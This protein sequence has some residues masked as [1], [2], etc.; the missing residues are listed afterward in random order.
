[1]KSSAPASSGSASS[2]ACQNVEGAG[3]FSN[4]VTWDFTTLNALPSDLVA[5]TEKNK[6]PTA[7]YERVA[8]PS[9]STVSGGYLNMKV[10]GGQS[11]S[12][13]KTAQ[14]QT[15][16]EGMLFASIRTTA[17]LSSVQ[18]ICHGF[19]FYNDAAEE[20]DIEYL[21]DPKSTSNPGDG[22]TPLQLT[23]HGVGSVGKQYDTAAIPSDA[24][25]KAHEY[26][27]D[28]VDG[29][30]SHYIDGKKVKEFTQYVPKQAGEWIWNN[31]ADGNKDWSLGPPA[32]DSTLK[33]SKIEMFYNTTS[34]KC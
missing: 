21:S 23:N 24:T 2:G 22:S 33:I 7:P 28:W 9:L 11:S 26:R 13:I 27:T 29:T 16:E 5:T 12:P 30:V 4:H 6:D 10:P 34:S 32:Q 8:D 3:V 1:M 14:L 19:F 17:I 25:T 20:I 31:W 15:K 18:G